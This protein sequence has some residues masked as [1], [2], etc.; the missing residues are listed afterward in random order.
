MFLDSAG[1]IDVLVS[2]GREIDAVNLAFAFKL[3]EMYSPLILL[4]SYLENAGRVPSPVKSP[5]SSPT[6]QVFFSFPLIGQCICITS[7]SF[8]AHISYIL[9]QGV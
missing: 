1:V 9:K 2:N 6:V 8:L 7:E 4:K 3:T 5:N